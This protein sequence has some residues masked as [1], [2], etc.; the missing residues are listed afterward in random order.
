MCEKLSPKSFKLNLIVNTFLQSLNPLELLLR[1]KTFYGKMLNTRF[2]PWITLILSLVVFGLAWAMLTR[3]YY[4]RLEKGTQILAVFAVQGFL[5]RLMF[6]IVVCIVLMLLAGFD[7]DPFRVVAFSSS[8]VLFWA[9]LLLIYALLFPI[10]INFLNSVGV[11]IVTRMD[12]LIDAFRALQLHP[13]VALFTY[14]TF[15]VFVVQLVLSYFGLLE[16]GAN[17]GNARAA[18]VICVA[19]ALFCGILGIFTPALPAGFIQDFSQGN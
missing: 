12:D 4:G 8:V 16:S 10:Q 17:A 5:V 18:I 11:P 19:G 9:L 15:V 1:P 6:Y 2:F 14:S 7:S 3:N 13:V